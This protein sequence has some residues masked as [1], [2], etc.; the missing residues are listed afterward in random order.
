MICNMVW[1]CFRMYCMTFE[2]YFTVDCTHLPVKD[3]Q[4]IF[5]FLD[6]YFNQTVMEHV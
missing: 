5:N 1:D 2:I 4:Q 6:E 3:K